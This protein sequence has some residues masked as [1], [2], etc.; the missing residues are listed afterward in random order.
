[1][2]VITLGALVLQALSTFIIQRCLM[3]DLTRRV[4]SFPQASRKTLESSSTAEDFPV[5]RDSSSLTTK[6]MEDDENEED[7][8]VGNVKVCAEDV[9]SEDEQEY[10]AKMKKQLLKKAEQDP[11]DLYTRNYRAIEF[12]GVILSYRHGTLCRIIKCRIIKFPI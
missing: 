3:I 10:F 6:T 7:E 4:F 11:G 2:L 1:M 9:D 8:I 12:A 5:A